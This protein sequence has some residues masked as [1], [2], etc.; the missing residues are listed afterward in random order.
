[1]LPRSHDRCLRSAADNA[2]AASGI[3]HGPRL[4]RGACHGLGN[5]LARRVGFER[6][7]VIE[8]RRAR[9]AV[10]GLEIG[11]AK[12][13]PARNIYAVTVIVPFIVSCP[14]PQKI[15][16]RKVNVPILSGTRRTRAILP[17]M[18]SA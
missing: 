4:Q 6:R 18:M 16:Q 2:C 9:C 5:V 13:A 3:A 17:G 14:D 12:E 15:S 10:K 1:P 8:L 11:R 7:G